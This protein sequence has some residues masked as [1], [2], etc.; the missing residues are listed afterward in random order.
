MLLGIR[1]LSFVASS[2]WIGVDAIAFLFVVNVVALVLS[3]VWPLVV[4]LAVHFIIF[5]VTFVDAAVTP[6]VLAISSYFVVFPVS[7]ELAAIAPLIKT[8]PMFFTILIFSF[9]FGSIG[10]DFFSFSF[11]NIINPLASISAAIYVSVLPESVGLVLLKLTN[12]NVPLSMPKRSAT[13]CLIV[14]P[15]TFINCS[16]VP[17]LDTV[18]HPKLLLSRFVNVHLSFI[19]W[20]IRK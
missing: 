19:H 14:N 5:P 12:I 4:S 1:P 20:S 7:W 17:L 10:P 9:V 18:A 3:T 8:V 15:L 6:E 16:I 2:V 11:L 13:W